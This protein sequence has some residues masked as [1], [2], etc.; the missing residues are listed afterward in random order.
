MQ[1]ITINPAP[2]QQ[3]QF[4]NLTTVGISQLEAIANVENAEPQMLMERS[5][6]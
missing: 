6:R 5:L 3:E 1:Y 4:Y 2:C